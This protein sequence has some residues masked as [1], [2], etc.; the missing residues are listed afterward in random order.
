MLRGCPHLSHLITFLDS[1]LQK[2]HPLFFG[3]TASHPFLKIKHS[4]IMHDNLWGTNRF[5][6]RELAI[7]DSPIL[8]RL[9]YI[10]QTGL[11][12][13]VYMAA[14]H[15]RFEHSIGVATIASR[16]FD[17]LHNRCRNI[18]KDIA[19]I[20]GKTLNYEEYISKLKQELRIAALLH[21]IG[22]SIH[23]HTSEL[24]FSELNLIKLAS[25]ELS[26]FTG[27]TK[28][29]AEVIAFC[30]TLSESIRNLLS[31]AKD[32]LMDGEAH[33]VY[34]GDISINNIALMIL[35]RA[36][37][38]LLQFMGDIISSDPSSTVSF[39]KYSD[40]K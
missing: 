22:H 8:Q 9:R 3:P 7:I 15:T 4:K 38:P 13:Q 16:I 30:I 10:H 34:Y 2:H 28:G 39:L 6:W 18:F 27:K 25:N 31:R 40:I 32:K 17:A 37:H 5:S 36:E 20:L 11:A 1:C 33:D 12:F 35:G 29:A 23:S 24:V 19:R 21:D 26:E 14:H